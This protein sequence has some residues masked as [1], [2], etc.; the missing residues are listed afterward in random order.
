MKT[1]SAGTAVITA[2]VAAV[3][4]AFTA[5]QATCNITVTSAP[6][7]DEVIDLLTASDF[8]ATGSSTYVATTGISKPSGAVYAGNTAKNYEA[9]QIRSKNND[10]GIVSTTS[11][12]YVKSVKIVLNSNTVSAREI[13]VYGSN[14]AYTSAADLYGEDAGT[15]LG[16][17][18]MS[19]GATG[20]VTVSGSYQYVGIRSKDG[21]AYLDSVEITWD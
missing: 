19:D 15:L 14:S 4:G 6:T 5:G 1:I 21:A 7:G 9:I 13:Q 11:G 3:E 12:G 2:S 10:S 8:D 18:K 20:T 17:V 16:S